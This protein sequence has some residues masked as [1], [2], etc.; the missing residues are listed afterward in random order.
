MAYV[1][2]ISASFG[3]NGDKVGR[4]LAERLSLPFLDRAIPAS[5]AYAQSGPWSLVESRD[6]AVPSRWER[7]F[8]RFADVEAPMGPSN[9]SLERIKTIER[10]RSAN[11][12]KLCEMADTTGAVI[13]GRA[14]MVVLGGRPNVLCVRL[15][16]PVEARISQ[17]VAQGVDEASARKAQVEVDRARDA[18]ARVLFNA[19]QNDC[20][21]YHLVLDST[22]LSLD[23]CVDIIVLAVSDRF[24]WFLTAQ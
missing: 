16:G 4:A 18:Y 13:L 17:V 8:M 14:G 19:R 3:A 7:L 21:L 11:E 20:R 6:E 15:S 5:A 1:V 2:T 9:M 12:V 24:D 10:F 23:T 22:V